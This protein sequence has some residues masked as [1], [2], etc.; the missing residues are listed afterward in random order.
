MSV[1]SL[2]KRGLV[3]ARSVERG[4]RV[5][6]PRELRDIIRRREASVGRLNGSTDEIWQ[7][8]TFVLNQ[9]QEIKVYGLDK[10]GIKK[11]DVMAWV[12]SFDGQHNLA[13]N[14]NLFDRELCN[15]FV[16]GCMARRDEMGLE[17]NVAD[18]L[19]VALDVCG[20]DLPRALITLATA[21]RHIARGLDYRFLGQRYSDKEMLRW[22]GVVADFEGD[23]GDSAGS[24]YHF[25]EALLGAYGASQNG[26]GLYNRL[27]NKICRTIYRTT[28]TATWAIRYLMCKHEGSLHGRA[29]TIGLEIGRALARGSGLEM[30]EGMMSKVIDRINCLVTLQPVGSY[31]NQA[32]VCIRR[33]S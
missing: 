9:R 2:P 20:N 28:P 14:P 16:Y 32:P 30:G 4:A 25:W 22:K 10:I 27:T 18:Q 5:E 19:G 11:L 21:T 29:D 13:F 24:N 6:Y 12:M 3:V 26:N 17:L 15:R 1:F 31:D 23:Q 7:G 8:M 33:G